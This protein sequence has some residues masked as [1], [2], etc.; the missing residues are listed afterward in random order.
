MIFQT[1]IVRLMRVTTGGASLGRDTA[2]TVS[3]IKN[4]SPNGMFSFPLNQVLYN[5]YI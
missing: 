4:D 5:K 2:V 3:I 1:F